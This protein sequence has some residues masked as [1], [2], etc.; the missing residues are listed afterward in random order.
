MQ[1]K[2]KSYYDYELQRIKGHLACGRWQMASYCIKH[3][4]SLTH[5]MA[6]KV[7][8]MYCDGDDMESVVDAVIKNNYGGYKGVFSR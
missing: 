4:Y 5:A 8:A 2:N 3:L 1:S 7:V 6:E